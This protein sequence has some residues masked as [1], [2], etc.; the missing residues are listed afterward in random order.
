MTWRCAEPRAPTNWGGSKI[1]ESFISIWVGA[2]LHRK[3]ESLI[4]FSARS[5]RS[6]R[7]ILRA[8]NNKCLFSI[9]IIVVG[10]TFIVALR[11]SPGRRKMHS[12]TLCTTSP[13]K[14]WM[15]Y[16]MLGLM[17]SVLQNHSRDWVKRIYAN[18]VSI[19]SN[20]LR[21]SIRSHMFNA[22]MLCRDKL[23]RQKET[24]Y[25]LVQWNVFRLSM[26]FEVF[27]G[28]CRK[29]V[30][31]QSSALLSAVG[32]V[33]DVI[34][35]QSEKCTFN[36]YLTPIWLRSINCHLRIYSFLINSWTKYL[37]QECKALSELSWETLMLVGWPECHLNKIL[38]WWS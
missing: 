14:I 18:W 8:C 26:A 31:A 32:V 2:S 20:R 15:K 5:S 28:E 7:G 4:P 25:S 29:K 17:Q 33:L 11:A 21:N 27:Q 12:K 30:R 3:W 24:A 10:F 23:L 37:R 38:N 34:Q 35:C 16:E 6:S 19:A 36:E 9:I 13:R 22:C 1:I